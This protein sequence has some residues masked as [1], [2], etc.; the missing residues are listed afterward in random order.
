MKK[1][2]E[3]FT[4]YKPNGVEVQVNENSLEYALS[5]GWTADKPAEKKEA[6]K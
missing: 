6:K 5:L 4:L 3:L 2:V 1:E